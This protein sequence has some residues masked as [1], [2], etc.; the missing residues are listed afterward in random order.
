MQKTKKKL[1]YVVLAALLVVL[2]LSTVLTAVYAGGI[3]AKTF[4]IR[5]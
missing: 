1:V 4:K 3:F 2:Q 5:I